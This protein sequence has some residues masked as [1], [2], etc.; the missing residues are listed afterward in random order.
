MISDDIYE[1][2]V[3]LFFSL[4]RSEFTRSETTNPILFNTRSSFQNCQNVPTFDVYFH[5][6]STNCTAFSNIPHKLK[7]TV[8]GSCPIETS[9][10]SRYNHEFDASRTPLSSVPYTLIV[11]QSTK[12]M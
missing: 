7:Y 10:I 6:I 2:D 5:S 9:I 3:I 8:R 12:M 1:T 11:G 4:R